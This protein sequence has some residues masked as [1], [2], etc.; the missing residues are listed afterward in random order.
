VTENKIK[1]SEITAKQ[2]CSLKY[3]RNANDTNGWESGGFVCYAEVYGCFQTADHEIVLGDCGGLLATG[4][5]AGLD[6]C[7]WYTQCENISV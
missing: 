7:T 6:L 2:T 4:R 1:L 3:T 5:I